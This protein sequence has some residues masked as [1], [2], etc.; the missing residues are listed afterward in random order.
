M[1]G[2]RIT[3][4]RCATQMRQAYDRVRFP[5]RFKT[6]AEVYAHEALMS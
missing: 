4:K 2:L 3:L 6:W 1:E 5:H